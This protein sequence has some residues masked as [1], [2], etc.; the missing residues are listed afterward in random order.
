MP[1][2]FT[3]AEYADMLFVYGFCNGNALATCRECSLW[4]HNRKVP[5]SRVFASAYNKLHETGAL[6]SSHI[7][8][9]CANKQNVDEV[10]SILQSAEHSPTTNTWRISTCI[11]VPHIRVWR[12]L[13]QHGLYPF[14][15]QMV[16]RLEEGDEARWLDLCWWVIDNHWLILFKL[17]TDETSFT[18]DSI[19]NTH[20]AHRWSDK[21][22]YA[23]VER[24]SQ[25]RFS[26]NV[27]CGVIDN[28]LIGPAV[29][30]NRLTGC[31]YADF[32]QNELPL[33]LEEVPLAKWMCMVFQ[34][35][36]APAHYSRLV[37][38]HLKLTFP[39][40][41]IGH[42][43]HVQWPPRSPDLTPLDFCLWG[44]MKSKVYEEKVNTRDELVARIMNNAALI[45]QNAKTSGQLHVLLP[46]GMKS[47]LKS[48]VGFLNTYFELLQFIEIIYITNKCN[49]YAMSFLH[50]FCTAFYA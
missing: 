49:Q 45:N 40:R 35:D 50:T 2:I 34:H 41:W 22:P 10:E 13:H 7:T 33:L 30:P 29:L 24:N 9:E 28:Q 15:L 11:G 44:W 48:M 3:H 39:E 19:N 23:I 46:R 16:Q 21:S 31:T 8:S 20:N 14:H 32:L 27:W 17:F 12:T 47:A 36:G 38:H 6:P 4:F 1:H 25:H 37:T 26:V 5:D 42:G 43:G 18:R